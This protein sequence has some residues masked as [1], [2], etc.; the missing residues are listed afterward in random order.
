M[1][2]QLP[3]E[4]KKRAYNQALIDRYRNVEEVQKIKRSLHVPKPIYKVT[5]Q[6]L[7]PSIH[8]LLIYRL[9]RFDELSKQ[10]MRRN[11]RI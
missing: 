5:H 7:S 10:M 6:H 2:V 4:R 3:Q 11:W 1:G 9:K 8:P